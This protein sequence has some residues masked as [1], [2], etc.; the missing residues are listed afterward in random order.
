MVKIADIIK[1]EGD[2]TT[3]IWKHPCEDFNALTQLIVHESQ[4]AIFMMNG[5]ALD[6]FGPGRYTLETQNIPLIGK[7]LNIPTGGY[8][9]RF[10]DQGDVL[11]LQ[12]VATGAEQIQRLAVHHKDCFLTFVY[13]QLRQCVKILARMLPDEGGVVAFIFDNICDF[14][15]KVPPFSYLVLTHIAGRIP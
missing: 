15:H 6:L 4:E 2:N 13:D 8:V 11:C 14:Y 10:A 5:Q 3:F 7:A 9:Q 1:Y 12:R